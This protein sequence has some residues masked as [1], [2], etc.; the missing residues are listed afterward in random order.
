M[1]VTSNT[2]P[3]L[4]LLPAI[5]VLGG[6]AVQLVR[7]ELD[8]ANDYGD[9]VEA[10]LRWTTLGAHWLHVV[11]LDAAFGTG[12]NADVISS[13]VATAPAQVEV[14]GGLRDDATVAR[15]LSTG[16][17]RISIGTAALEQPE[18][19]REVLAHL[20][21]MVAISLDVAGEALAS[22]GWR[23]A[24]G[25]LHDTL[26]AMTEAGCSRFIVTDTASDGTLGGPNLELLGAV[27]ARTSVPI[28]A[29]GGISSI[30]HI[31]QLRG[32][33]AI[34]IEGAIIGTALY[35]GLIDLP[36]ALE[37]AGPVHPG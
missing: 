26:A 23:E 3:E 24:S 12:D 33:T 7:G 5:D 20:G 35:Q 28:I 8:T 19:C 16:C 2:T 15:A 27:C 9:P 18:W 34:G 10:A 29:S 17:A 31:R 36:E 32:L 6:R 21:D 14:S 30:G 13:I 11:D 37:I 22:H 1:N 25:N 4:I